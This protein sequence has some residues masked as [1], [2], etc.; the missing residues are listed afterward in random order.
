MDSIAHTV[1]I[2]S[3]PHHTSL[4]SLLHEC[5]G[6]TM[7]VNKHVI[8]AKNRDRAY[9]PDL[10]VVHTR[11]DGTEVAYL[12]DITTD[13]SEGMNE[14]GIGIVNTALIV[15]YDEDEKKILKSGGKPSKDGARIRYA[16]SKKTIEDVVEA[17]S[18][19]QGGVK[20]HTI[21]VSQDTVYTVETTSKH[22]AHIIKHKPGT[23]LVRTNHGDEYP[24]AG[25]TQ[26]DEPDDF[27]SSVARRDDAIALLRDVKTVADVLPAMRTQTHEPHSNLNVI[28]D[29]KK[30]STSSQM[31]L[32][33]TA[34]TLQ[35]D[36]IEKYTD[37]MKG[38]VTKLPK[39]YSPKI[40]IQ[41]NKITDRDIHTLKEQAMSTPN[42]SKLVSLIR[43]IRAEDYKDG[44]TTN[45]AYE[46]WNELSEDAEYDGRSVELNKP[47]RSNDGKH[48]FYVYVKNDKNN[49]I[50]LGFGDPNAEIKRD[51]PERRKAYRDRHDC[52]NP[53]PKWKAE[54]WSCRMWA[55][56]P[57]SKIAEAAMQSIHRIHNGDVVRG[58]Y[59]NVPYTGFVATQRVHPTNHDIRIFTV[60]LDAPIVVH[61]THMSF[62]TV[63]A[64]DNPALASDRIAL[65]E[66]SDYDAM[67]S[68]AGL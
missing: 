11:I 20:G 12:H 63:N 36:Y 52:S 46:D 17:V 13:W 38:V 3:M 53:G 31:L 8:L 9:K 40:T 25:Y 5:I 14:Y 43:N 23:F 28:R 67:V 21:I 44:Q 1:N 64:S 57:V 35:L 66:A 42:A 22:K 51:D 33:L 2:T 30:M 65:R 49:V 54:Y 39:D 32:D 50:K 48:K 4:A 55:D 29:T 7:R 41:I 60:K 61:G 26:A 62:L 15:G 58:T 56:K 27:K 10:E 19:Y 18:S 47:F 6:V 16:L 24:D 59:M 45:C 37:A 34:R 68:A